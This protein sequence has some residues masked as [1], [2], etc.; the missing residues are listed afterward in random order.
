M[1]E[2]VDRDLSA[3]NLE[4]QSIPGRKAAAIRKSGRRGFW[5]SLRGGLLRP[6]PAAVYLVVAV[7]AVGMLVLNPGGWIGGGSS[8]RTGEG[9]IESGAGSISGGLGGVIILPNETKRERGLGTDESSATQIDISQPHFLLIE[10]VDLEAPPAAEDVY[11]VE[12]LINGSTEPSFEFE[13]KGKAFRDNYTLCLPLRPE[14][15]APG[16]YVLRVMNPDGF[17]VFRSSLLAK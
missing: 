1:L 6:V 9:G 13:V 7:F 14:S 11:T 2:A 15:L 5:D 10:L 3:D 4:S 8:L 12:L 17:T 16:D